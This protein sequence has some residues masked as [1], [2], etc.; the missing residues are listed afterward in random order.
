[1]A[2]THRKTDHAEN[3][4]QDS[5]RK[6]KP[7]AVGRKYIYDTTQPALAL[8]ITATGSRTFY[9]VKRLN[10]KY[11]RTPIGKVGEFTV[12]QARDAVASKLG[13]AVIKG[14]D[15]VEEKREQRL[16]RAREHTT[17]GDLWEYYFEQHAKPHKRSW[18]QD[19]KRYNRHLSSWATKPLDQITPADVERLHTNVGKKA[20]YEANRLLALI[21]T[22]FNKASKIEFDGDNP[23]KGIAKFQESQR[24]RFLHRDE[25][26][27]FFNALEKLRIASPTAADVLEMC[28]WTAAQKEN[29]MSMEWA[30][31]NI[32]RGLWIIPGGKHK[33]GKPV[34]VPLVPQA[35]AILGRRKHGADPKYVFPGRRR[36]KHIVNLAKPWNRLLETAGL[37]GVHIHDLRRTAGSWMAAG[38]TS[39]HLIGKALGHAS[40]SATSIY[41]RLDL[42]PVRAAITGAAAA[43]Q[44]AATADPNGT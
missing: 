43:I 11:V 19:E 34:N 42:D 25:I 2:K 3:L 36:G 14:I 24:E 38:G 27:A 5:V 9:L 31:L 7:P 15:P 8:C 29:V 40:T 10:G 23:C 28:V 1:M 20:P 13:N 18:R 16:Q 32:D 39:L 35:I 37:K 22:M 4:T 33:N 30:D 17:L 44:A 21:S 12:Q 41:A 26:P 6:V